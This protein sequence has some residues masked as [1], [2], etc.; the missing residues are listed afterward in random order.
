MREEVHNLRLVRVFSEWLKRGDNA[1]RR[2][3]VAHNIDP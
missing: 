1:F 2:N 3:L